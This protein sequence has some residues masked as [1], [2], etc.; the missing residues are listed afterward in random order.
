MYTAA[1]HIH[2]HS[3]YLL[4]TILKK[5]Y[6]SFMETTATKSK[7]W[8]F[9]CLYREEFSNFNKIVSAGYDKQQTIYMGGSGGAFA[10]FD[11]EAN[12]LV[13]AGWRMYCEFS[14]DWPEVM[15]QEYIDYLLQKFGWSPDG[16]AMQGYLEYTEP[17]TE[18]EIRNNARHL[19][20]ETKFLPSEFF[21]KEDMATQ[22]RFIEK[23]E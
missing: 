6:S 14:P 4:Q 19:C 17:I 3:L 21:S 20:S 8:K 18:D 2:I 9:K 5:L 23:E 1:P 16:S 7:V 12:P 10:R 11:V 15:D 22:T 13:R